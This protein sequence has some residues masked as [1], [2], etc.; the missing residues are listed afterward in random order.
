MEEIL[1][2]TKVLLEKIKAFS[3]TYKIDRGEKI[4]EIHKEIEQLFQRIISDSERARML[5]GLSETCTKHIYVLDNV[6]SSATKKRE[7]YKY[8]LQQLT[9]DLQEVIN[10]ISFKY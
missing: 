5:S 2:D 10:R 1:S 3:P 9:G 6:K 7:A 8:A 4:V